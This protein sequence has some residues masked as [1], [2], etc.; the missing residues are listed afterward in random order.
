M[1]LF[2]E[3][4]EKFGSHGVLL[5]RMCQVRLGVPNRAACLSGRQVPRR[6]GVK[7]G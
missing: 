2:F 4:V 3:R 5:F 1:L 7:L 6:G